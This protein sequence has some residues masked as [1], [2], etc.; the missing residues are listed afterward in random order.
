[1]ECPECKG[2]LDG[3]GNSYACKS[4]GVEWQVDFSCEI[5]HGKPEMESHC[6][7]VTFF[8]QSCRKLKSRESMDKTFTRK[9]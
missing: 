7:A 1:M 4:C 6:G 9:A 2:K 5:C 3:G 8:C